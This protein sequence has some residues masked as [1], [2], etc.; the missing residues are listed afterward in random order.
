MRVHLPSVAISLLACVVVIVTMSQAVPGSNSPRIEYGPHPRDMI[1]IKEGTPY[2]V[3]AGR[4]F[5][6]TALGTTNSQGARLRVNGQE[7]CYG[8]LINGQAVAGYSSEFSVAAVP[9]GFTVGEGATIDVE[10]SS[11]NAL[12]GRAWGYL[13]K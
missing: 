4:I 2:I 13:A 9:T 6:L 12:T 5:V 10:D 1:Q 11:P 3:P 7:E 8:G